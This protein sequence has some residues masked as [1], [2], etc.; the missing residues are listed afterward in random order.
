[1]HLS[2][3]CY[4]IETAWNLKVQLRSRRFIASEIYRTCFQEIVVAVKTRG[5]CKPRRTNPHT[6]LVRSS[7]LLGDDQQTKHTMH[8]QSQSDQVVRP[9]PQVAYLLSLACISHQL[10]NV[11]NCQTRR[12][13]LVNQLPNMRDTTF[14][15]STCLPPRFFR[16]D[17]TF[18]PPAKKTPLH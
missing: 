5:P 6:G 2:Q 8:D 1:M 9:R 14:H 10:S 15:L 18:A 4:G 3:R 11:K 13:H 17:A 7:L 16:T 12:C